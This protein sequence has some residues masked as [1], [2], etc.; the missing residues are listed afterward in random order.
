MIREMLWR[1]GTKMML[2]HGQAGTS[3]TYKEPLGAHPLL[4][5][6]LPIVTCHRCSRRD[7]FSSC[8]VTKGGWE[9]IR[10]YK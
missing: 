5:S 2:Y 3:S 8:C 1:R 7:T 6:I 10:A 9:E 4:L